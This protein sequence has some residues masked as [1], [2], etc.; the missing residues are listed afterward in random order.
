MAYGT[1][2]GRF[3]VHVDDPRR[4]DIRFTLYLADEVFCCSSAVSPIQ[5]I[6]ERLSSRSD[7][8]IET[9]LRGTDLD[10][11]FVNTPRGVRLLQMRSAVLVKF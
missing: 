4:S 10:V 3:L 6:I 8:L 1:D 9:R 7:R 2:I 11:C 5:E